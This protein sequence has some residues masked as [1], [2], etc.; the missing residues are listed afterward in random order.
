M[1]TIEIPIEPRAA[2][3]KR[4]ARRLRREGKLPAV[5]YG[6]KTDP[7]PLQVSREELLNRVADLEGSHLIRMKSASPLLEERVALIKEVQL[8]PVTGEVLHLDFYEVDLTEKLS[9]KVP[10]HFVGKPQ[11]VVRGGILQPIVREIEVECLPTDIPEYLNID[12]SS[13]DIGHAL[14]V[15]GLAMPEGVITTYDS[16]FTVVT[17]VAPTVEAPKVEEAPAL[18]AEAAEAVSAVPEEK[19]EGSSGGS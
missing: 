10:L 6:P 8:H 13:L 19:T 1:E 7:V 15:S 17:V 5:F 18:A 16:D 11:G 2:G 12:V 14:H 9:V 3:S 4:T